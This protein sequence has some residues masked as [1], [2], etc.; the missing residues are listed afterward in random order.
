MLASPLHRRL[1]V[2]VA[3]IAAAGLAATPA[4]GGTRVKTRGGDTF[5]AN[6]YLSS[7][8]HF[9]PGVIFV[10]PGERVEW[11]DKDRSGDP[12][13]ITVVRKK[14]LPDSITDI[15]NCTICELVNQHLVD[16]NDPDSGIAT[17]FVNTG[18]AGMQ[19][20]GDSLI[21]LPGHTIGTRVRAKVGRRLH[22]ICAIHPWMRGT[23]RVT[24]DGKRPH[25][26]R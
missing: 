2:L 7:T 26:A 24:K 23:I 17:L 15:F 25:R 20:Q 6:E 18:P 12:H 19:S 10:R 3:T 8:L 16:P 22:Y 1:A 14:N 4:L 9:E 21:L 5:S 13:S 11:K